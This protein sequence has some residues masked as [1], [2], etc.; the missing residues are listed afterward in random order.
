M[1]EKIIFSGKSYIAFR[2]K[3]TNQP[4]LKV[5]ITNSLRVYIKDTRIPSMLLNRSIFMRD[6]TL[7][8]TET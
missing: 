5:Q 8:L 6:P 4:S 7:H 1:M 3:N 2:G